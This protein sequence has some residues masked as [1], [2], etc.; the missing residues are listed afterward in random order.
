MIR[1]PD[2]LIEVK[3]LLRRSGKRLFRK[4]RTVPV[5]NRRP[6]GILRSGPSPWQE[7]GLAELRRLRKSAARNAKPPIVNIDAD[8]SYYYGEIPESDFEA[9]L[10]EARERDEMDFAIAQY[11]RRTGNRYFHEYAL[12]S[13]RALALKLLG[14]I[15]GR[16]ILDYGCGLGSLSVPAALQ[17]AQ[18]TLVDSCPSRGMMYL[19]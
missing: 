1:V 11:C 7:E 19:L 8:P 10:D 12:D 2:R 14:P 15:G 4:L 13:R 5:L 16:K 18:V 17:G 6:F 9:I 3:S